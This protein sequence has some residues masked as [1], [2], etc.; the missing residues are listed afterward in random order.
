MNLGKESYAILQEPYRD[1]NLKGKD[2]LIFQRAVLSYFAL[3]KTLPYPPKTTDK[4]VDISYRNFIPL[5]YKINGINTK[6]ASSVNTAL[7]QDF[8]SQ[9]LRNGDIF[10]LDIFEEELFH[11]ENR[12]PAVSA[13]EFQK[14]AREFSKK[15][16]KRVKGHKKFNKIKG[17]IAVAAIFAVFAAIFT[18]NA[19]HENSKKPVNTGLSSTETVEL[20]YS[21]IHTM[22]TDLMLAS[23]KE[24]P[25]AQSYISKIPQI[26]VTANMRA[27]WNF[28]SGIS[29][30]ENWMFFEPDS[31]RAYS[32]FIFGITNFTIDGK[33]STLNLTAPTRRKHKAPLIKENGERLN[34]FSKS[35]HKVHYFLVHNVDNSIKVEEYTTVVHLK[36]KKDRWQISFLDE[37]SCSDFIL[38]QTVC[39]A[40]KTVFEEQNQ[41]FIKASLALKNI[42]PWLPTEQSLVEEKHRLDAVGYF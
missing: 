38:P 35:E 37:T 19:M 13:E 26:Y 7:S 14:L 9:E 10:H 4:S 6:L 30:P 31:S 41:D 24:C 18:L 20:F 36:W 8:K 11:P 29:T 5:E 28:E 32:H 40:Y 2:A 21:G 12:K 17:T 22:N 39:Q 27:A 3:T 42:F 25:E 33:D 23:A 34:E 1:S 16:Q 15:Q